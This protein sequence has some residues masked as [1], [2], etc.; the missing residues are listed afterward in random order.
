MNQVSQ[1]LRWMERSLE[2]AQKA[3]QDG[4]VPV[5]AVIVRKG[6]VIGEGFNR[7]EIDQD[8]TSHAEVVAIRAAAQ[9]IRGWRLDES[10]L[11]VTLEPCIQ[12]CGAILLA[13]I[14]RLVYGC[15][16]PKAGGVRSL[17]T[18][19]KDKRLNHRVEVTPG[20]MAEE[21]GEILTRFFE[22]LRRVKKGVNLSS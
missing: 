12:C 6:V 20:V 9:T 8:P 1:D 21:C 18:L 22:G 19:L 7:R 2:L 14:P 13:R 3:Y 15:D 4:E 11:Y 10:T 5:G 16:D 17:Y